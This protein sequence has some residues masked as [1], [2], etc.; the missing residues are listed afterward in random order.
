[1]AHRAAATAAGSQAPDD[2]LMDLVA[3]DVF[4]EESL[5][6]G[7]VA[8]NRLATAVAATRPMD[9]SSDED[10]ELLYLTRQQY[11]AIS[12]PQMQIEGGN[13]ERGARRLWS[14][15]DSMREYSQHFLGAGKKVM[16]VIQRPEFE[17]LH[18][19]T[20]HLIN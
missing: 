12:L 13:R 14:G 15:I 16:Y 5:V 1:M 18:S 4:G 2:W 9:G 11:N 7:C 20:A 8:S 17:L 3:G 10:V 6:D 19:K